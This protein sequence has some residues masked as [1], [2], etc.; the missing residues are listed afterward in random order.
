MASS[1][2]VAAPQVKKVDNEGNVHVQWMKPGAQRATRVT[3]EGSVVKSGS[4][5]GRVG[6]AGKK[7]NGFKTRKAAAEWI[8]SEISGN[9]SKPKAKPPASK[10]RGANT[11]YAFT[12]EDIVRERDHN[13]QSWK[14]VAVALGLKTPGAA[15]TAYTALT[16]RDHSTSVMAGRTTRTVG[17]DTVTGADLTARWTEETDRRIIED[18]LRCP[19]CEGRGWYPDE[20]GGT[21][22]CED[23][24]IIR[25]FLYIDDDGQIQSG[26][27]PDGRQ[28]REDVLKV[29]GV[30][31]WYQATADAPPAVS[32]TNVMTGGGHVWPITDF[33]N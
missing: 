24:V 11:Q 1:S 13:G 16:G 10:G 14:K 29:S 7:Q 26:P 9:G 33:V 15:R 31:H 27:A 17:G 2:G 3:V 5:W 20:K 8:I 32:M 21:K 18:T 4:W 12:E 22:R 28:V 23:G 30:H 6:K 25:R 19:M